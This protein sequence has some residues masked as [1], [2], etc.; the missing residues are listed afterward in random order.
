[1][2]EILTI[3]LSCETV[4]LQHLWYDV[5]NLCRLHTWFCYFI[6]WICIVQSHMNGKCVFFL[7]LRISVCYIPLTKNYL[8]KRFWKVE[9][10]FLKLIR[11]CFQVDNH[12]ILSLCQDLWYNC[13]N[14]GE[15]CWTAWIALSTW[16]NLEP[17][18]KQKR[19]W[20]VLN[21]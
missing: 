6:I 7:L 14:R 18:L 12:K 19:M 1:M 3:F 17:I 16:F 10:I 21:N 2:A 13:R 5:F 8:T 15:N 4:L 20:R 9:L 11:T